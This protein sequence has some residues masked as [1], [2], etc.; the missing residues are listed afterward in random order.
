ME[1]TSAH[2]TQLLVNTPEPCSVK[3]GFNVSVNLFPNEKFAED[4]FKFDRHGRTFSEYVENNVGKGELLITSNFSISR[5]VFSSLVLQTH[6]N[7]G[8]FGE[9]LTLFQITN[10]WTGP[11]SKLL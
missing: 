7:Q 1:T 3:T 5:S 9:G 8:L 11:N 10:F 2:E 6:K 4:N